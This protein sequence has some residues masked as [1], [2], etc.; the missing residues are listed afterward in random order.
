ML[1]FFV[2]KFEIFPPSQTEDQSPNLKML[3]YIKKES[4]DHLKLQPAI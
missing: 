4:K 2:T 1:G 3:I